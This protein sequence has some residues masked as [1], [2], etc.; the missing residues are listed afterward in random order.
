MFRAEHLDG[1]EWTE[2]KLAARLGKAAFKMYEKHPSFSLFYGGEFVAAGGIAILW[3]GVAEAW[4]I[5]GPL[6]TQHPMFLHRTVIRL[7]PALARDSK[8]HRLQ[9]QVRANFAKSHRWVERLGFEKEAVLRRYGIDGQ[10]MTMYT[11]FFNA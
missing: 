4:L 3:P 5:A 10:D 2:S 11:R 9:V 8:I 7:L 1:V 6:A